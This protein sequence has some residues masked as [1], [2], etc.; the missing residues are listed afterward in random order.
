MVLSAITT[1]SPKIT[2]WSICI[3]SA[4]AIR[5]YLINI[6]HLYYITYS[7]RGVELMAGLIICFA[8]AYRTVVL[9]V[10]SKLC[11]H[12]VLLLATSA[13]TKNKGWGRVHFDDAFWKEKMNWEI[14][15]CSLRPNQF[16]LIFHRKKENRIIISTDLD[17]KTLMYV[18]GVKEK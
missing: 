11:L 16:V 10:K 8:L 5:S 15:Y 12:V 18:Y 14:S 7:V 2:F 17:L 6:I 13:R 9:K 3:S 4:A 1:G